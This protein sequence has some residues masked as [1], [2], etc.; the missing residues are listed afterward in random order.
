VTI[1]TPKVNVEQ[2]KKIRSL[3]LDLKEL[4]RLLEIMQERSFAA[5]QIEVSNYQRLDQ[6]AEVFEANKKTLQ[7]GFALYLT[8]TGSDGVNLTGNIETVFSSPNFPEEVA[9]VFFDT[10]TPL[11]TAHNWNPRN[12][13]VVF[14]DFTRPQVFN[15]SLMPSQETPNA[16]NILVQGSDA[17][18]TYG[19]YHEFENF[20]SEHPSTLRM[21][22]RHTTYDILIWILGLPL[23]FWLCFRMAPLVSKATASPFLSAAL[24]VYLFMACLISFRI[25]FHYARW[26]WPLVEFRGSRNNAIRHK[27][28]WST[29]AVSLICS[30]I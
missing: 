4:R 18:W 10:S 17:T 25:F 27:L 15:F 28:L 23:A 6:T 9:S 8:V 24:Y 11:R 2:R 1:S 30:A 3:S 12:K 5:G 7:E 19:I 16:S 26:I 14:I 22:H 13:C 29:L 20:V 21:L